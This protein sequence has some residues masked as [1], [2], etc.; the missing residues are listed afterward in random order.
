MRLLLVSLLFPFFCSA[1]QDT[2]LEYT[3]LEKML[4]APGN[5]SK[6]TV[7]PVGQLR[8]I[9]ITGIIVEELN[10]GKIQQGLLFREVSLAP[11]STNFS[12][13]LIVDLEEVAKLADALTKIKN[14]I[15]ANKEPSLKTYQFVSEGLV[16]FTIESRKVNPDKCSLDICRRYKFSHNSVYGPC[17]MKNSFGAD[18]IEQLIVILKVYMAPWSK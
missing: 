13:G 2:L 10:S 3:R 5:L 7:E 14:E 18:D 8:N 16:T 6:T 15:K 12:G 4:L 1:Q 17:I 9:E 11:L